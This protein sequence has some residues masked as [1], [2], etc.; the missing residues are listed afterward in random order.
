MRA[1]RDRNSRRWDAV[2][3]RE[4]YGIQVL[5]FL[6]EGSGEI[7]KAVMV[8]ITRLDAHRELDALTDTELCE[9]LDRSQPW[10]SDTLFPG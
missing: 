2:V 6:A 5:L 10:D 7:R 8:S 4:S 9:R 3:G 1:F